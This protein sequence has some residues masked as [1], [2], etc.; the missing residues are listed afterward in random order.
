MIVGI[1]A[2]NLGYDPKATPSPSTTPLDSDDAN[3]VAHVTS[4]VIGCILGAA[5]AGAVF[6][7][8]LALYR[9]R[10]R[11]NLRKRLLER[12]TAQINQE[13]AN[14][15]TPPD[16]EAR[17]LLIAERFGIV[18]ERYWRQQRRTHIRSGRRPTRRR[19]DLRDMAGDLY[20]DRTRSGTGVREPETAYFRFGGTNYMPL[21]AF[22]GGRTNNRSG[23]G[24]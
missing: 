10:R 11:Q 22:V 12:I 17:Q 9:F 4:A 24:S 13:H 2:R 20:R 21:Y 19:D 16:D 5:L 3:R 6:A 23:G 15:E 1:A 7:L 8:G 14:D 18:A